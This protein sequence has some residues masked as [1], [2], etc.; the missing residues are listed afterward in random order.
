[1]GGLL[2][3]IELT[4]FWIPKAAVKVLVA[5]LTNSYFLRPVISLVYVRAL[6]CAAKA[7]GGLVVLYVVGVRYAALALAPAFVFVGISARTCRLILIGLTF[8]PAAFVR[9]AT[10]TWTRPALAALLLPSAVLLT[11]LLAG[12]WVWFAALLPAAW[13]IAALLAATTLTA[14]PTA[15]LLP[16]AWPIAALLA[17]ATLTA[18]LG[19]ELLELVICT[20]RAVAI[21]VLWSFHGVFP[22][23]LPPKKFRLGN[24]APVRCPD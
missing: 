4:L 12:A 21:S 19:A 23:P 8:T 1:L 18:L 6:V 20:Q 5:I 24:G 11:A 15:A 7:A 10:R 17:A 13:P 22:L 14:L 16:A 9:Y 3:S 2:G